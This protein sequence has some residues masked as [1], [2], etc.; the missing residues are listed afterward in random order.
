MV[1]DGVLEAGGGVAEVAQLLFDVVA[2]LQINIFTNVREPWESNRT[3]L[4]KVCAFGEV[5]PNQPVGI[6]VEST[7]P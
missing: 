4:V 6:L 7:L 3:D 5:L 1:D 2:D